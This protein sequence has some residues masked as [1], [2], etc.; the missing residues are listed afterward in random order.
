MKKRAKIAAAADKVE[1]FKTGGGTFVPSVSDLDEQ[2][3]AVLGNRATPLTN[4]FDSDADYNAA[5]SNCK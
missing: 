5:V 3:L 4:V 2:L 1:L